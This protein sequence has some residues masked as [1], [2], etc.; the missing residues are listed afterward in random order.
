MAPEQRAAVARHREHEAVVPA[1]RHSLHQRARAAVPP[2]SRTGGA[3]GRTEE[4][5]ATSRVAAREDVALGRAGEAAHVRR[6]GARRPHA[7]RAPCYGHARARPARALA[8]AEARRLRRRRVPRLAR[9]GVPQ[10]VHARVAAAA[11]VRAVTGPVERRHAAAVRGEAARHG[12]HAERRV[13]LR[14]VE[15]VEPAVARAD[16]EARTARREAQGRRAAPHAPGRP[17]RLAALGRLRLGLGLRGQRALAPQ[18]EVGRPQ[19]VDARRVRGA[20]HDH[21]AR[22]VDGHRGARQRELLQREEPQ[23]AASRLGHAP[24]PREAVGA[25]RGEAHLVRLRLRLRLRV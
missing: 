6:R 13:P 3:R 18:R 4:C 14:R 24:Q 19:H 9:R 11:Q 17:A 1:E 5:E 10:R 12:Q 21:L 7:L 25:H 22:R 8:R 15:Q 2:V 16:R 23:P 20:T